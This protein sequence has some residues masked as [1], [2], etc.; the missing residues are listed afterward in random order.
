MIQT[1]LWDVDETL[2]NFGAAQR[3]ALNTLFSEFALGLCTDAM[4]ARYDAINH[5]F[6]QRLEQNEITK[7]QVLTGRFEQFFS[8]YGIGTDFIEVKLFLP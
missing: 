6:W 3:A 5:V 8:E 2:L 1:I 7:Q 4:A